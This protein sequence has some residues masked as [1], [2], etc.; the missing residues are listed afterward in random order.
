M[1]FVF[2]IYI[3]KK[4]RIQIKISAKEKI[5]KDFLLGK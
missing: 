3:Y 5:K 4:S 1:K 2:I